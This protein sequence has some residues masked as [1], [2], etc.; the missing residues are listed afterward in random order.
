[1]ALAERTELGHIT[2]LPTGQV[3]VRVDTIIERDGVELTRTYHREVL[4]PGD[5][6]SRFEPRLKAVT[7]VIWT[8]KVIADARAAAA[9]RN[10]RTKP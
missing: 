5:D 7:D 1:M 3:L 10:A 2:L 9:A 4:E 8:P 6:V